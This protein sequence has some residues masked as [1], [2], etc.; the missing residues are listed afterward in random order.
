MANDVKEIRIRPIGGP[1]KT[2]LRL[3]GTILSIEQ[4]SWGWETSVDVPLEIIHFGEC[5][6]FRA[7]WL[8]A[9]LLILMMPYTMFVTGLKVWEHLLGE[10]PR[11]VFVNGSMIG[12]LTGIIIFL[13]L[14]IRFFMRQKTIVIHFASEGNIS[15]W[16]T[17]KRETEIR[18][19]LD[20]MQT[21]MVHV[22]ENIPYALESTIGDTFQKPLMETIG[23]IFLFILPSSFTRKPILLWLCLIPVGMYIYSTIQNMTTPGTFRRAMRYGLRRQWQKAQECIEQC[24]SN[25]PDFQPARLLLVEL[26]MQQEDF[27][28][29]ECALAGIQYN[30]EADA[31]Q[32]IQNELILRKRITMRKKDDF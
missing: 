28:G 25:H 13:A 1:S 14:L 9:A 12:M 27:Q 5:K 21:R 23:L 30:L 20:E 31:V 32:E 22:E 7:M 16:L 4:K 29:A 3:E 17:R 15:F 8:I 2:W 19:F 18:A 10:V 6:Q 11:A 24:I 26:L